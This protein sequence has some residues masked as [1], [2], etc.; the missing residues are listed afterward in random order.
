MVATCP[1][2]SGSQSLFAGPIFTREAVVAPRRPRLYALRVVY[3]GALILVIATAWMV[4]NGTQT[5]RNISDMAR[6][7]AVLLLILAPLQLVLLLFLSATQSTSRVSIEKDRQTLVLLLMT[8][9]NNRE[10]VLGKMLSSLIGVGSMLLTALPVFMLVVLFG[11]TSFAQVLWAF[12]VTAMACVVAA[13]IGTLVGFWREKTFQSLALTLLA[14]VFWLGLG[15]LAGTMGWRIAGQDTG[16]VA[17]ALSPVRAIFATCQPDVQQRLSTAVYPFLL[18]HFAMAVFLCGLATVMVRRWNPSRDI[19]P[20]QQED[21]F[22]ANATRLR[23]VDSAVASGGRPVAAESA[24]GSA[25]RPDPGLAVTLAGVLADPLVDVPVVEREEG[26]VGGGD[27]RHRAVWENPVLWREMCTWAYGRK[28]LF[29]RLAWWTLAAALGAVLWWQVSSGAATRA[30]S[31][32]AVTVPAVARPLAPLMIVS[33]VILNALAV[34]SITSERD[35]KA[36][37][38]LRMTDL[39]PREFLLGKLLGVLYVAA[40]VI[41]VPVLLCLY[42]WF[43]S[44]VTGENLVFLLLGL[45]ILDLFVAVLGIHCGMVYESSRNSIG[46]SLGTVFF[47]FLGMVTVMLMMVSFTGNVEAQLT[48]FL[49]AIIGG[50]LGL[51]AA[52]GWNSPSS[53]LA[54]ATGILPLSM[55]YCITSLLLRN[56]GGVMVV[57]AF[58]YG[59]TVVAL[60]VPKLSEFQFADSGKPR[61]DGEG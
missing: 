25:G 52:L 9:M 30:T 7:G 10:L 53:A 27:L 36:L 3:G 59:F 24:G 21:A 51:Y 17:N 6:F 35:G 38:L 45:L 16:T 33:L 26:P 20:G 37:D 29:I 34:T 32:A 15:E 14:V 12:A 13:S 2:I 23:G 11:G 49:A 46:V 19:R 39:S 43:S 18:T 50:A 8:R 55:F 4:I 41:L 58:A 61:M 60:A 5:V 54:L 42:L 28:I 31:S 44:A 1:P 56:Y 57:L 47:L 40:D 48:P 22:Q